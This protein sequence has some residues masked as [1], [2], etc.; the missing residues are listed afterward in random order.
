MSIRNRLM[1]AFLA[2]GLIPMIASLLTSGAVSSAGAE[3]LAGEGGLA[4]RDRATQALEG[5]RE[6]RR[7]HVV[8]YLEGVRAQTVVFSRNAAVR[9]AVE[10]LGV[11]IGTFRE[12][13]D[14]G[15]AESEAVAD[16]TRYYEERFGGAGVPV[17]DLL[18]AL[19]DNA[20]VLQAFYIARNE[21][22]DGEKDRMNA[23]GEDSMYCLSHAEVHPMVRAYCKQFG[24]EDIY[25][26]AADGRVLHT[27][28]KGIEFGAS[29]GTGPLADTGLARAFRKARDLS[30]PDAI[31][32]ED[33]SPYL[34][35]GGRPCSFLAAP[36]RAAEGDV[37]GVVAFRLPP[38]RLQ[39][40]LASR[41]GLGDTGETL[42]VGD[43]GRLRCESYLAADRFNLVKAFGSG[44]TR[45]ETD[46]VQSVFENGES[47]SDVVTDYLGNE[48]LSA[49]APVTALGLN[50]AIVA[51]IDTE[52][53]FAGVRRLREE[54][55]ATVSSMVTMNIVLAILAAL[56]VGTIAFYLSGSLVRPLRQSVQMLRDVA[57]GEGDLTKRLDATRNDELGQL[58]KWFNT[59]VQRLQ[60]I[61][62]DIRRTADEMDGAAHGL[63]GTAVKLDEGATTTRGESSSVSSSANQVSE[64]MKGVSS[65][66]SEMA[67]AI[68]ALSAIVEEISAVITEVTEKTDTSA[69][70]A[71]EAAQRSESGNQQMEQLLEAAKSIGGM[72][73]TIQEIAEQTNLLALN[74]T[75]EA[76]RAGEAG[77]GFAVVAEEVKELARQTAVATEDIRT[78]VENIQGVASSS[79]GSLRAIGEVV[80]KIE[81]S[82]EEI[83]TAMREQRAATQ[84]MANRLSMN[85]GMVKEVAESVSSAADQSQEI[86]VSLRRVDEGVENARVG[87]SETKQAGSRVSELA[88]GLQRE[89]GQFRT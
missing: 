45:I 80:H 59:F 69:K 51:K 41:Y 26:L 46:D 35:A 40:I 74:A 89:V 71:S 78:R 65:T 2:C 28:K 16:L 24:F 70:T 23:A 8:D 31:A 7:A 63:T 30:D 32:V 33:F 56:G 29:M 9:K 55:A 50:W 81:V 68:H 83:A 4:L 37:L 22:P 64:R 82:S 77:R 3:K 85:A 47:S 38:E 76:A 14:L 75:I 52:E 62:I 36:V 61:I 19:D 6:G 57:E 73:E 54:G 49:W 53:A 66:T 27:V 39:A 13:Q 10:D 34:P 60:Q 20:K 58:A 79:A 84:E 25:V 48:V 88:A 21:F 44:A 11:T 86:T 18:G 67:D 5:I 43:D 17:S 15:D 87:A 12:D 42:L 72:I 1:I